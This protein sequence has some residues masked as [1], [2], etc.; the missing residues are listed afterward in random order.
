MKAR[1]GSP[2]MI[3]D[4]LQLT[5]FFVQ[6]TILSLIY[7]VETYKRLKHSAMLHHDENS[8]RE[9]LHHLIWVNILVIALDISLLGLSYADFFYV[10][11]AYKPCVYG[12]KLRVEFAILNRLISSVQRS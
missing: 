9:V 2:Y 4:K 5:V 7:I 6:E 8:R 10:Q 12:V 11:S 1:L 3:W